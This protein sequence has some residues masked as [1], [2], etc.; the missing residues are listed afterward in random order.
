MCHIC[1]DIQYR[2]ALENGDFRPSIV[3]YEDEDIEKANHRYYKEHYPGYAC[4]IYNL[5]S[6]INIWLDDRGLL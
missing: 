2:K 1:F 5:H 3:Y 4:W 6:M